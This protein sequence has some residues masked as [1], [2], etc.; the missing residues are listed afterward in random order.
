MSFPYLIQGSNIVIV[1]G[2][3]SHTINR[4]HI[5]YDKI[6]EAIKA[7]DWQQVQDLVEPKKIVL[8]YSAGNISIQGD[9]MFWKDQEFHNVLALRLIKMFQEGFPI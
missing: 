8:N 2:T 5:A 4:A 9:K 7:N 1:I 6:V 3:N